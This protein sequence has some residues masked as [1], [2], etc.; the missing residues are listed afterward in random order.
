MLKILKRKAMNRIKK[1]VYLHDSV[2]LMER[3]WN[4][5]IILDA[6]RYD[7]FKDVNNIPAR[8]TK[9]KSVGSCTSDWIR[10][11]F[12]HIYSDVTV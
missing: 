1:R 10:N 5:L 11:T 9:I 6:C 2:N 4:T 8:L 3:D 12:K 7:V